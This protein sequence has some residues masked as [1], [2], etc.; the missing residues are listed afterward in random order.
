M[1]CAKMRKLSKIAIH[2]ISGCAID[3][4]RKIPCLLSA[5]EMMLARIWTPTDEI[6]VARALRIGGGVYNPLKNNC[7]WAKTRLAHDGVIK[8]LRPASK[9]RE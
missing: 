5:E 8:C 7:V 3:A 4:R 2:D 1:I 9:N 6:L